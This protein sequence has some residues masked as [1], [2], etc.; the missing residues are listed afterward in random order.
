[1]KIQVQQC[2][3]VF[4]HLDA[5]CY[6]LLF[7]IYMQAV[8]WNLSAHIWCE[9]FPRPSL[10]KLMLKTVQRTIVTIITII[11]IVVFVVIFDDDTYY[12]LGLLVLRTSLSSLYKVRWSVT[13]K[14]NSF[15]YCKVWCHYKVRQFHQKVRQVLQR[16]TIITMWGR[17]SKQV[18][19]RH[20]VANV[21]L[22][23]S[24][25]IIILSWKEKYLLFC[26]GLRPSCNASPIYWMYLVFNFFLYKCKLIKIVRKAVQL[27]RLCIDQ[28][29][30]WW[31]GSYRALNSWKSLEI[32]KAIIQTCK[33]SENILI[34]KQFWTRRPG[35]C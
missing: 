30:G 2:R 15:F 17:T 29:K 8:V 7:I 33:K 28:A 22:A 34:S 16:A 25:W 5:N 21:L 1:M 26:F 4:K 18:S 32:C 3:N 27:F 13:A 9:H 20:S 10:G 31:Q 23:D 24:L 11:T 35:M 6:F 14:C 12:L 19:F